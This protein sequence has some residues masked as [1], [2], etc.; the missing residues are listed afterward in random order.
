MLA[1]KWKM[2][3]G[4]IDDDN[5]RYSKGGNFINI[6]SY[7]LCHINSHCMNTSPVYWNLVGGNMVWPLV[8]GYGFFCLVVKSW[9]GC[10]SLFGVIRPGSSCLCAG[11]LSE[12]CVGVDYI[13]AY[14]WEEF[15]SVLQSWYYLAFQ[16]LGEF[17]EVPTSM[18]LWMC[19]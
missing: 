8:E 16:C 6:N 9:V 13:G 4:P 10:Q 7:A 12:K 15:Y 1:S 11:G 2:N 17:Q 14:V 18:W 5:W 19:R 3:G